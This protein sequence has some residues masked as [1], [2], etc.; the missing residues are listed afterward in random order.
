MFFLF[1]CP[2]GSNCYL[3]VTHHAQISALQYL[4]GVVWLLCR[5]GVRDRSSEERPTMV[6]CPGAGQDHLKRPA[7]RVPRQEVLAGD[8]V[9][10]TTGNVQGDEADREGTSWSCHSHKVRP[11]KTRNETNW[12]RAG[13]CFCSA[14]FRLE[15]HGRLRPL[16]RQEVTESLGSFTGP[17]HFCVF[18]YKAHVVSII[19]C[20][21]SLEYSWGP[22]EFWFELLGKPCKL[23]PPCTLLLRTQLCLLYC[24][25]A[26]VFLLMRPRCW[27]Y[28]SAAKVPQQL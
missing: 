16:N 27:S 13:F 3:W 24:V 10:D 7:G 12:G 25:S 20:P 9:V 21:C 2:I 5:G 19:T 14:Q 28:A 1:F 11:E 15:N 22:S 17:C 23:L 18:I 6:Q 26:H 8:D 4:E